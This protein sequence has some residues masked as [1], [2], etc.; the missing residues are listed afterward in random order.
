M[1]QYLIDAFADLLIQTDKLKSDLESFLAD[2]SVSLDDR[3]RVWSAAP[4]ILKN[5]S[6][7]VETLADIY[8]SELFEDP[9]YYEKFQTI[10]VGYHI[11]QLEKFFPERAAEA[12]R[13]VLNQNLGSFCLDW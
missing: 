13:Q 11:S 6:L 2:Q 5:H 12:K 10:D 4:K 8:S 9:F 7:W 3:W 1:S